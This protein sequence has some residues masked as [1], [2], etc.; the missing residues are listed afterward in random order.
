M[1]GVGD[2]GFDRKACNDSLFLFPFGFRKS[3]R[4]VFA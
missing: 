3:F 2:G 4:F 1:E